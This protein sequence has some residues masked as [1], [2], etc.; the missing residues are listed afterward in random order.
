MNYSDYNFSKHKYRYAC[1]CGARHVLKYAP[2]MSFVRAK[3]IKTNERKAHATL[4]N[5]EVYP[6]SIYY[7]LKRLGKYAGIK[8][9]IVTENGAA[10]KDEL[11]QNNVDDDSRIDY[12][13]SYIAQV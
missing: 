13:K 7:A 11:I 12:L 5:W 8:E 3:I 1:S 4:M 9:I 6:E 2:F 10:S